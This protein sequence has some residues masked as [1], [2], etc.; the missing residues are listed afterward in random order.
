[1]TNTEENEKRLRGSLD[2]AI[3]KKAVLASSIILA[4]VA[5]VLILLSWAVHS[6]RVMLVLIPIALFLRPHRGNK[7]LSDAANDKMPRFR[8]LS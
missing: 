8:F 1:M 6:F 7:R 5:V 3:C 4:A 2:Y